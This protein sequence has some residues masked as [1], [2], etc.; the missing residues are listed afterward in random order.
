MILLLCPWRNNIISARDAKK[1]LLFALFGVHFMRIEFNYHYVQYYYITQ[2]SILSIHKWIIIVFFIVNYNKSQ[3]YKNR[4]GFL[5][6]YL[7]IQWYFLTFSIILELYY[8]QYRINS[9]PSQTAYFSKQL[10]TLTSFSNLSK[11]QT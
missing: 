11:V 1:L 5:P 8:Y 2:I 10:S 4:L 7:F 6:V 9:Q 3:T